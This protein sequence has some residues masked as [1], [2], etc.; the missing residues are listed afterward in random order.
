MS[1]TWPDGR[2]GL[3]G[4]DLTIA[5]GERVAVVGPSGAG[6]STLLQLLLG[7][8][9][10]DAGTIQADGQPLDRLDPADWRRHLAWVPQRPHLF[11][12][13]LADNLRLA[14]PEAGEAELHQALERAHCMEFVKRLPQGLETPVGDGGHPLSGGQRQRL[15]L[16]RA[17]L[18]PARLVLLDEPTAHLDLKSEAR[19]Q[20]A[21]DELAERATLIV[22][23][24]RL[25]SV[26]RAERI[27]VLDQ[28]RLVEEGSHQALLEQGGFYAQLVGG[29]AA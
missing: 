20:A 25:A 23:A 14:H 18:R 3:A 26:R 8:V 22:V 2:T 6:K 9:R 16:A 5:A 28:G 21:V 7:F 27:L 15:A 10:P 11:A 29:R 17:F 19:I 4:L 12:G 24:H 1:L 13:T